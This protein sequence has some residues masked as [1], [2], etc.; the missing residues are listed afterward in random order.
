MKDLEGAA[1]N[2]NPLSDAVRPSISAASISDALAWCLCRR[3]LLCC[4]YGPREGRIQPVAI[5][6][7]QAC[8][9][10]SFAVSEAFGN[11]EHH[12]AGPLVPLNHFCCQSWLKAFAQ[13]LHP[14][15]N[16]TLP[17]P[18][19]CPVISQSR[20]EVSQGS[21][22][23]SL[24]LLLEAASFQLAL[25]WLLSPLDEGTARLLKTARSSSFIVSTA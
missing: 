8:A 23:C 7:T 1:C 19:K 21:G 5:R 22:R 16:G 24:R 17:I 6:V 11:P 2:K 13:A 3:H 18:A 4:S 10:V 14:P 15:G 12:A 9:R 20:S 25:Q